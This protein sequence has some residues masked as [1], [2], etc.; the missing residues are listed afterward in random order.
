MNV[1]ITRARRAL[2]IVGDQS[3][4]RTCRH[5][6]ALESCTIRGCSMDAKDLSDEKFLIMNEV[7]KPSTSDPLLDESDEFYGLFSRS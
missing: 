1:A 4:L 2:I 6:A 3:V 5:W 7:E